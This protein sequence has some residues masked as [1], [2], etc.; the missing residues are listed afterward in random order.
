MF[1]FDEPT[2][3]M[4][5]P[6]VDLLVGRIDTLRQRGCGVVYITHKMD[7]MFRLAD[8]ITVLRDGR[9]IGTA[10]A[11]EL[12]PEKLVEW[13]VGRNLTPAAAGRAAPQGP[14]LLE[15]RN[16]RLPHALPD[17]APAVD[18]SFNLH[19][20]EILGIAGLRGSGADEL[21]HGLFDTTGT[22]IQGDVVLAGKPLP[23]RTPQISIVRGVVLLTNDRKA[24]GLAP[25][26]SVSHSVSLASLSR[27]STRFG[28]MRRDLEADAVGDLMQ[29]FRLNAPSP[30]AAVGVLSGGNQQKTYLGRCLLARPRVLLLNEPTRGID[31]AAKAEIHA[32]MRDWANEGIAVVMVTTDLEE[33]FALS[34]RI[35]VMH[36]GRIAAECTPGAST[37]DDV[38]AAAMGGSAAATA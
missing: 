1:V 37:R 26:L 8:S 27:F 28:W 2:S 3:A 15:V 17:R 33:L 19:S 4:H 35:L 29:R 36:A 22:A 20:G 18:V 30:D 25:H 38:L 16:F 5:G 13:M 14:P 24:M 9:V 23:R 11:R 7:E 21:L 10:A 34:D 12:A 32:L 6:E 31:V